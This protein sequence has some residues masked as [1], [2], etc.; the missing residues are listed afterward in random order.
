MAAKRQK[1]RKM[2]I[3]C[4]GNRKIAVLVNLL[5]TKDQHSGGNSPKNVSFGQLLQKISLTFR[6]KMN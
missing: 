4:K 1:C 5:N 6:L 3:L 2:G